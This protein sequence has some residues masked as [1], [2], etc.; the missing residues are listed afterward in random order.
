MQAV[1]PELTTEQSVQTAPVVEP[2]PS[3]VVES[4]PQVQAV[5]PEPTT[6][7]PVQTAPTTTQQA[8]ETQQPVVVRTIHYETPATTVSGDFLLQE[9][10]Q[11]W[12]FDPAQALGVSGEPQEHIIVKVK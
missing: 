10:Q 11:E 3:Q 8:I 6:E 2:T 5:Q 9:P 1:Q 7:Q 12:E 4:A